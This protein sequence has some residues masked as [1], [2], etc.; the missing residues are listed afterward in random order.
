MG[1]Y[2]DGTGRGWAP[3]VATRLS[4]QPVAAA[5][6]TAPAHRWIVHQTPCAAARPRTLAAVTTAGTSAVKVWTAQAACRLDRSRAYP[7]STL[8][9][10]TNPARASGT[11]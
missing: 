4:N 10:A 6:T 5:R 1:D 11:C 7:R 8:P 9:P 2:V 3:A